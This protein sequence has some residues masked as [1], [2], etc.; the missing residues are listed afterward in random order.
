MNIFLNNNWNIVWEELS[1]S[2]NGAISEIVR[3]IFSNVFGKYA[4]EDFFVDDNSQQFDDLSDND[5]N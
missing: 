3:N 4:Y 2:V 5:D 1:E